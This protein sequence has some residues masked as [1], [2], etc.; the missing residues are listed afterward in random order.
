MPDYN[1]LLICLFIIAI[2]LHSL[3]KLFF[4]GKILTIFCNCLVHDT[5]LCLKFKEYF[6]IHNQNGLPPT[7]LF[8]AGPVRVLQGFL[9]STGPDGGSLMPHISQ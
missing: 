2:I 8:P 6:E 3:V 7:W 1:I 9:C 4:S 5:F